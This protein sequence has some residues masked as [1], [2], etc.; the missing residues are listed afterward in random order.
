MCKER[1]SGLV[2]ITVS[3]TNTLL[4]SGSPSFD[5]VIIVSLVMPRNPMRHVDVSSNS[6][7]AMFRVV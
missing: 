3:L 6:L 1:F 2:N 5:T 4:L 7:I